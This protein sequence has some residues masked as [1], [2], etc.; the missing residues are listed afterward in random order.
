MVHIN[1]KL[2]NFEPKICNR[3]DK[4]RD[5]FCQNDILRSKI[6]LNSKGPRRQSNKFHNQNFNQIYAK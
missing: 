4:T 2:E 3:L 5:K 6:Q 1:N